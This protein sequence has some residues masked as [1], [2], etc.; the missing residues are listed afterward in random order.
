MNRTIGFYSNKIVVKWEFKDSQFD[1]IKNLV[2]DIPGRRWSPDN[3]QWEIPE[4]GAFILERTLE[5]YDF[6]KS[7]SYQEL[8]ESHRTSN[9]QSKTIHSDENIPVPD[10]LGYHPFQKV[11]I[12]YARGKRNV[13]NGDEMGLGKTIQAIG[14]V[15]ENPQYDNVLIIC[16]ASLKLNWKQELEKWL[17]IHYNISIIDTKSKPTNGMVIVNYD[18]V[19]KIEWLKSINWD[20][21]VCDEVHFLKNPKAK[22]TQ[23]VFGKW[24]SDPEKLIS[25]IPAK[26][27]VY[28]TGTPIVNRPIEL[29]PLLHFS[30][31]AKSWKGYVTR[32]CDAQHDGYGWDV[33]G[34]SNLGELQELLRSNIMIRRL[35]KDVMSELPVKTRQII[36]LPANGC[37]NILSHEK[38]EFGA[39]Q[40]LL[41]DLKY[42]FEMAKVSENYEE[43]SHAVKALEEGSMVAFERMEKARMETA[44]AKLPY[45]VEHI[46]EAI[47]SS[48]KVIVFTTHHII[49]DTIQT[50]FSGCAVVDGRTSMQTRQNEVDRFQND[51]GCHLFIGSIKAAGVGITL[52]ASKHVI[53]AE[54]DWV[55]GNITQAEDRCYGRINDPHGAL[56][57]HV[58]LSGSIDSVMART[59][60]QKQE[61]ID[62]AMDEESDLPVIPG[63]TISPGRMRIIREA[64]SI[65]D[66]EIQKIH[67]D[68][69]ILDLDKS[70]I[71]KMDTKVGTTLA[72]LGRLTAKQAVLGRS[73]LD[74]F[75]NQSKEG[76]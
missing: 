63:E 60:I 18:I 73:I 12:V 5:P 47:D 51:P 21:L 39:T 50:E 27:R 41:D 76:L 8:I 49:T 61:I 25:P 54:F 37:A 44:K 17:V 64:E 70:G 20:L 66:E 7:H 24:D 35:K 22:R 32:Y 4:S 62:K 48:G 59:I 36:E 53:F 11:G 46:R 15:N 65:T 69:R 55:P 33:S 72:G 1:E 71:N 56:A 67:A 10:G 2:K 26:Q 34:A 29:W 23:A 31:L 43:Y 45:L 40:E 57:Q 19:G 14:I 74:K 9:K 28:L 68:L 3:K 13:L 52:T 38:E 58:V 6:I 75:N 42:A 16:P 30:G